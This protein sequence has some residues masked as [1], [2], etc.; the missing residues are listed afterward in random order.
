[1]MKLRKRLPYL[2]L[3]LCLALSLSFGAQIAAVQ[4]AAARLV[5]AFAPVGYNVT[6][7]DSSAHRSVTA[8]GVRVR[9]GSDAAVLSN[10]A[11]VLP[12]EA[13]FL[14]LD[15]ALLRRNT[16]RTGALAL[17]LGA[18]VVAALFAMTAVSIRLCAAAL[19]RDLREQ[20]RSARIRA[21]RASLHAMPRT[22]APARRFAA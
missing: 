13:T 18:A 1:M 22:A 21:R 5:D 3:A 8:E 14:C 12:A 11:V 10:G 6:Y 20:A 15:E 9:F 4:R 7:Y 19:R 17:A 16:A 2:A